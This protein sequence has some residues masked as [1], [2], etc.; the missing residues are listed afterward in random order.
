MHNNICLVKCLIDLK[1][2]QFIYYSKANIHPDL[3]FFFE[4]NSTEDIYFIM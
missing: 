3:H 1:S 4:I 2:L